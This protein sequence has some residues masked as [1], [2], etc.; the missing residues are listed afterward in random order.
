MARHFSSSVD[1]GLSLSKRI[2]H[3]KGLAPAPVPEMSR[4]TEDFLPSAPMCYAV[5]PD[6]EIVD[7][8]DIRS[9]QPYVYGR[10][11]PPALI[12]L[13]LHGVAMEVEC[14]LDTA[15]VTVTGSWRVHCVRGS[16]VCDCQVAIP[17]G[18]QV[19]IFSIIFNFILRVYLYVFSL[20]IYLHKAFVQNVYMENS[21]F[22][23]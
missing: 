5:I 2:H 13:L 20:K 21:K 12:P 14:C 3:F 23:R 1:F 16:S 15:F 18:E 4:S 17:M 7:N 6:P 19:N 10:C 9:Y 11:D 22:N 8:P